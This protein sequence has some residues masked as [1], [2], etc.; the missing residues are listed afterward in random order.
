MA[1]LHL[2]LI[3]SAPFFLSSWTDV[4]N[5]P[6]QRVVFAIAKKCSSR[7]RSTSGEDSEEEARAEDAAVAVAAFISFVG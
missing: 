2:S 6:Q 7:T 4:A 5:C 3:L 1:A